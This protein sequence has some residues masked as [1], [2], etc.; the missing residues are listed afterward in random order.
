MDSDQDGLGDRLELVLGTDA[1]APDTSGVIVQRT[2]D[3]LTV[4]FHR[5]DLS[6]ELGLVL[7]VEAGSS[8]GS[9]PQVFLIGDSTETSSPGVSVEENDDAPDTITVTIPT[10][11]SPTFFAR[12]KVAAG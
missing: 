5:D 6:E 7:A 9:W 3:N 11:G 4:T 10:N 8:L 1:H 2:G 12:V